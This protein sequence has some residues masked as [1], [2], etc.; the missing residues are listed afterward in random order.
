MEYM[1]LIW[2]LLNPLKMILRQV[3][4]ITEF[5]V[6]SLD[7]ILNNCLKYSTF[8]LSVLLTNYYELLIRDVTL[9]HPY[10]VSF[11]GLKI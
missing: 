8:L 1:K 7:G 11:L 2:T 10:T 6:K 4:G 3:F 9:L 5:A